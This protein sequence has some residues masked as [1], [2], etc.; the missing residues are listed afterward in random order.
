MHEAARVHRG[1]RQ[2]RRVA[3]VEPYKDDFFSVFADSFNGPGEHLTADAQFLM[4]RILVG[5]TVG[6][7][8]FLSH[9][10]VT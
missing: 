2:C 1:I 7:V 8:S 9:V 5:R 10:S 4:G 3:L 6:A